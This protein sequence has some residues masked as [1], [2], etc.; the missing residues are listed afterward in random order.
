MHNLAK[1]LR[2]DIGDE[3]SVIV[4]NKKFEGKCNEDLAELCP[5]LSTFFHGINNRFY[6]LMEIFSKQLF[7]HKDFKGS[8]SIKAVLSVLVPTLSYKDLEIR[9]GGMACS[10]WKEMVFDTNDEA[11]KL[12]IARNLKKYCELDTLAMVEIQRELKKL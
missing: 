4:W 8:Y 3:G 11:K 7:V 2:E 9:D 6:D 5:E 10:T 1:S 12:E